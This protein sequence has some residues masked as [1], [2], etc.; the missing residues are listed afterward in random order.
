M[1]EPWLTK[2]EVADLLKVSTRTIERVKPPCLLVGDQNRYRT[3]EIEKGA[4]E[5]GPLCPVGSR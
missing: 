5:P 4:E 3:S 2:R 1:P